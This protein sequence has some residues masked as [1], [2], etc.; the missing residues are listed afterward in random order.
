MLNKIICRKYY[1]CH[2]YFT[3]LFC[4]NTFK[5]SK[6]RIL[7]VKLNGKCT[8]PGRAETENIFRKFSPCL[9]VRR[10]IIIWNHISP[11]I[12]LFTIMWLTQAR[13]SQSASMRNRLQ[14]ICYYQIP[15]EIYWELKPWGFSPSLAIP[16]PMCK[17][18][19]TASRAACIFSLWL[20]MRVINL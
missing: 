14:A 15:R 4:V 17:L 18:L 12:V 7:M 16:W 6:C 3:A 19:L 2:V 5:I 13:C 11:Y 8:W 1:P 20:L 10:N 9:F